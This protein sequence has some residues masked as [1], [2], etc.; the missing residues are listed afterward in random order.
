MVR[1][2][3]PLLAFPFFSLDGL[4]QVFLN[5]MEQPRVSDIDHFVGQMYPETCPTFQYQAYAGR[6][7]VRQACGD[8]THAITNST[9]CRPPVIPSHRHL[10]RP[11]RYSE[12]AQRGGRLWVPH[13]R[14]KC[15]SER[16]TFSRT[17]WCLV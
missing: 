3:T 2:G 17:L 5:T 16:A 7:T 13:G 14:L 1:P 8:S 10:A 4:Q 15:K 11:L 12:S 9:A 6:F